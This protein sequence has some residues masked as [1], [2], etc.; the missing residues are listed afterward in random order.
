M[1][2][3]IRNISLMGLVLATSLSCSN[4]EEV[5]VDPTA[6]NADQ[7]QIEYFINSSIGG[8]QQDPNIAERVFVLYWDDAGRMTRVG[9]LSEGSSNDDWTSQYYNNYVSSWLRN[10]NA[11]I[12]IA[13]E[14]LEAG[15]AR[16]YTANLKQ[17]ARIWRAYMMSEMSDNFGPIPVNGFQGSNPEYSDVKEVYYYMLQELAEATTALDLSVDNADNS[18]KK[19]DPAYGY[20]YVKWKKYGNSLRMRLAMRLSEVDAAKAK[21]EFEAAVADVYIKDASDNFAVQEVAG[22]NDYTGVMTREWWDHEI[23]ATL[24]NLMIGLGGVPS[25]NMLSADKLSYIKPANYMGLKFENHFTSL[26]NDPSAGF[27]FDGLHNTIDPRAYD[28]YAIP[29]DFNN[30]EFNTYPSWTNGAK[31]TKRT[32]VDADNKVVKEIDAAYSW[33]AYVGG[34]WGAKGVKNNIYAY[35][36]TLPR[37]ANKYRN[38]SNKRIFFA[39][40]ESYFLIAEAA[41]RG[42]SVPMSGQSAYEQGIAASF[43]YNGVSGQLSTYLA[44][45]DYS[46]VGTSVSWGHTAE[47][48]A[49]VVMTFKDGY[50]NATGTYNMKYP[51]NNIYKNGTVKNDLLTKIITQKFIAQTPWLPLE[52]W[53][54]HR[55]LGLPF[56]ENPAIETPLTDMPA[57][58]TAN[59]MTNSIKFYGQRLKYPSN[60]G[61]NIPGGYQ[62]ALG[63]LGGPDSVFTP[64][65][66]AKQ[67]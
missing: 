32:L 39:S 31:T 34:N 28:L 7:V 40:W 5:N 57:L 41:V 36:G 38:S 6:A 20:D 16:P 25:A 63:K 15:K 26:T 10:I 35:T 9:T 21:Q 49:T 17:V 42:W 46:R 29:G 65:W 66:W 60:F 14:Q 18:L 43:A 58:T 13:D 64:L 19:L 54:D 30:P 2:K 24:N 55:R 61:S 37:L 59:Y 11:G 51:V 44:S 53:S 8:A 27:F 50:T 45:Q 47:P 3:I 22:Y 52:T 48:P 12:K 62:Q 4:F 56:F 67:Q 33:N 23:S 1:K